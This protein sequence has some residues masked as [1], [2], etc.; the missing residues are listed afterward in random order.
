V[1][2]ATWQI[3]KLRLPH[4]KKQRKVILLMW[5]GID[6]RYRGRESDGGESIASQMFGTMENEAR[7][8]PK[9][10][11]DM[12]V[13]LEVEVG[14]AHARDVYGYWGFEYLGPREAVGTGRQYEVLMRSA[15]GDE[16]DQ[17]DLP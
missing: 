15:T 14:N 7:A 16:D 3:R 8:S 9:A 11:P 17:T 10:R 1:G 13:A 4:D 6:L 12:P 5:F 2:Y